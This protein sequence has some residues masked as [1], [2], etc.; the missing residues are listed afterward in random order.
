[1]CAFRISAEMS[2]MQ[3]TCH[4]YCKSSPVANARLSARH[5]TRHEQVLEAVSP[6][7]RRAYLQLLD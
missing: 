4:W 2:L 1:M 7:T 3:H 6:E 5:R